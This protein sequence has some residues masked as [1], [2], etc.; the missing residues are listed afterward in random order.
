LEALVRKSPAILI[1]LAVF[2]ALALSACATKG[3]AP[4][5][6]APEKA[7]KQRTVVAKVP[8][9][10]KETSFYSD[11]LIDEY[12]VY[13]LDEAKKL[14][15]ER[16]KFDAS[17]ADPVERAV[18]EYAAARPSV[19]TIYES[20]GK[21]RSRR[22]MGYDAAGRLAS[23][24]LIDAKGKVLSSSTYSYDSEGRKVEWRALDGGG[25]VKA[26][27]SYLYGKAELVGVE[28]KDSGG[29]STGS[30]KLEYA[31]GKLAKRSYF[32]SDKALQQY[33]A[34][35]YSG[36]LLASRETRR[37]D[38]SIV[39]KT[40]FA[41]GGLG[42]LVKATDYGASGSVSGYATYEYLVREDSSIE[43]YYE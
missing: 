17:R 34:Y 38:G 6:K 21:L 16:D 35:A 2:A 30:I 5:A 8:V 19:E 36:A 28:M 11:E 33:E 31:D 12:T 10:V 24:R 7:A 4:A 23:E 27:T 40:A 43:T 3:P 18:L 20:D 9:L 41:Y 22:E 15:T 29:A 1:S 32:G 25:A 39:S 26:I 37:A 42:E 14:A 13:K